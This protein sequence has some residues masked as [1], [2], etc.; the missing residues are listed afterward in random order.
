VDT[1]LT[2]TAY[3]YRELDLMARIARALGREA[4]A[5]AYEDKAAFVKQRFN[6]TFYRPDEA[7]YRSAAG[8]RQTD[9]AL[10]LAFGLAP[11]AD[12]QAIADGIARD[13]EA[14]GGHLH[15]GILGTAVLFEVLSDFGHHELAHTIAGQRTFPSYGYLFDH[16]ADTL[17]ESWQ[18]DARSRNHHY[19]GTID[20]WFFEDVAGLEPDP[21]RPGYEHVLIRPRPGGGLTHASAWH[22]SP[23]GRVASAWR[24]KRD[25]FTL[26]VTLPPNTTGTVHLPGRSPRAVGSGTHRFETELP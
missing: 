26:E 7:A 5:R 3:V 16:G 19:L 22:D 6:E 8:Y 14:R 1:R 2:A 11:H 10:A 20:R 15:T 21:E 9:N 13:A 12:R 4:D 24:V 23:Y 18:L 25:R 17:W